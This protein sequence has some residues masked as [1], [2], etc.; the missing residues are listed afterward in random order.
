MVVPIVATPCTNRRDVHA[1]PGSAT[2]A[3][4]ATVPPWDDP[5]HERPSRCIAHGD[6]RGD[7]GLDR[8]VPGHAVRPSAFPVTVASRPRTAPRRA[9]ATSWHERHVVLPAGRR[10]ARSRCRSCATC[11]RGG[12]GVRIALSGPSNATL[13]TRPRP[14]S[15]STTTRRCSRSWA[16]AHPDREP[17]QPS[18]PRAHV[19]AYAIAQAPVRRTKCCRHGLGDLADRPRARPVHTATSAVVQASADRRRPRKVLRC[20]TCPPR[21]WPASRCACAAGS[22][23]PT[24][25]PTTCTACASSRR[26]SGFAVQQRRSQSRCAGA[27]HD[28]RRRGGHLV[29]LGADARCWQPP[30]HAFAVRST[31]NTST[32]PGCGQAAR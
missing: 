11:R 4:I 2:N 10:S 16:T 24:A 28:E 32:L 22:A 14:A 12:R 6:D 5:R 31:V 27:E 9:P 3:V 8:R 23:R 26:P 1:E 20:R 25:G 7:G 15:S 21:S 18:G 17:R 30:A 29:V 19:D 13:A